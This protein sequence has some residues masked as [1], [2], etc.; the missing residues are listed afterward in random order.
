MAEAANEEPYLD[1]D[2]IWQQIGNM[3]DGIWGEAE[4][5]TF[6][7]MCQCG[8]KRS[9]VEYLL[10]LQSPGIDPQYWRKT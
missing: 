10:S 5:R 4:L 8:L 6:F 2:F 9:C 7:K 1:P 3:E